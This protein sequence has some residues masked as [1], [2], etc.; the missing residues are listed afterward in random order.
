MKTN[1]QILMAELQNE[2]SFLKE[3]MND[4]VKDL[5]FK[6][7]EAFRKPFFYTQEK[8]RTLKNIDDSNYGMISELKRRIAYFKKIDVTPGLNEMEYEQVK[9]EISKATKRL[10][11]I[12][13]EDVKFRVDTDEII[14]CLEN[15][16]LR[17]LNSFDLEFKERNF[18]ISVQQ[19]K[20]SLSFLLKTLN[21]QPLDHSMPETKIVELK[22]IG[23]DVHQ[24]DA[25]LELKKFNASKILT[26]L[27]I[28]SR[29]VY[30][31][32]ELYGEKEALLIF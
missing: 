8:L 15:I 24:S 1:L 14:A 17:K 27:E 2:C 4:C 21:A 29:I 18:K 16:A 28:L 25:F 31:V 19:K 22:K 6:G 12:I 32:L 10:N 5:D 20:F 23:F 11:D 7:A 9:E 30:D 26:A 13:G 3:K